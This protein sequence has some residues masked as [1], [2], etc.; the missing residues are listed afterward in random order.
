MSITD[1]ELF[2]IHAN[3]AGSLPR[4]LHERIRGEVRFDDG[5]RALYATDGSNYRQ[6]PIGVVLPR[7]REDLEEAVRVC[8]EFGAA[9]TSRGCGTSLAGQCCNTAVIIDTS[10]YV[11]QV[12]E[13]DAEGRLAR[14]E[15]GCILDVLRDAAREQGL[16]FGPD[17]STHNHCTLGGMLGN[18]SCGVHSVMAAF[19][20]PGARTADNTAELEILTYDGVKLRVGPTS[21]EELSA[22]IEAGG[23]KGEIYR[24]LRDLR[25]KYAT[26]IRERFPNIPRRVSGYNLPAIATGK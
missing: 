7:D 2:A 21:D 6:T 16:T 24:K 4:A 9:I 17:P 23:R 3:P 15:P 19:R 10:K 18:D 14:V 22:I 5:S 25:D 20:G 11:N 8:H 13:I 1:S 12:L 26:A